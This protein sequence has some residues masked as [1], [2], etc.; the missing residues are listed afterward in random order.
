MNTKNGLYNGKYLIAIYDKNDRPIC[1]GGRV[2]DLTMKYI[3]RKLKH[4]TSNYT[5]HLI[6]CFEKHNDIFAEEDEIFLKELFAEQQ[7]KRLNKQCNNER[8]FYRR[9][10]IIKER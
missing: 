10:E 3:A 8:T 7:Q 6:D 1:V 5:I 2:T 9:K 4:P